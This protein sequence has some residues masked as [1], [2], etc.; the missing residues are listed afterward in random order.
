MLSS[1]GA[2]LIQAGGINTGRFQ[3]DA[4]PATTH[5]YGWPMNNYWTTNFNAEQR[6][7]MK[8]S[9]SFSSGRNSRTDAIVWGNK[10]CNTPPARV[11][12][13]GGDLPNDLEDMNEQSWI[14]GWPENITLVSAMTNTMGDVVLIQ[15]R[16]TE[17]LTTQLELSTEDGNH[18]RITPADAVG[19]PLPKGDKTIKPFENRFFLLR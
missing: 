1:P 8:F 7:S 5:I 11:I 10:V 17:G 15:V 14:T 4:R 2:P 3:A 12:P 18:Y 13:G 6:G 9:Y 16:E 19:N